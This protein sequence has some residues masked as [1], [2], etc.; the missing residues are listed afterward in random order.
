[1]NKYLCV[2]VCVMCAVSTGWAKKKKAQP[3]VEED[4]AEEVAEEETYE[5]EAPEAP[6]V[7]APAE[8]SSEEVAAE[9][10]STPAPV[11][12]V[13][14]E[15]EEESEEVAEESEEDEEEAE[16]VASKKKK[17]KKKKH[18]EEEEDEDEESEDSDE[19]EVAGA[20]GPVF[21]V[22]GVLGGSYI[23][24]ANMPMGA[25][26]GLAFAYYFTSDIAVRTGLDVAVRTKS[27]KELVVD[28]GPLGFDAFGLWNGMF[29]EVSKN[30]YLVSVKLPVAFRYA[31]NDMFW[32][33]AGVTI[34]GDV[35]YTGKVQNGVYGEYSENLAAMDGGLDAD[36]RADDAF[37]GFGVTLADNFDVGL[38]LGYVE[39]VNIGINMVYWFR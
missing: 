26:V 7:E 21:G 8:E 9:E 32:A 16:E 38:Q 20:S 19:S 10:E 23:S 31:I 30:G 37:V 14:E 28:D 17:S 12:E 13:A 36:F 6:A 29:K 24:S 15:S 5:E 3:V 27:S 35:Y 2:L 34:A 39:C 1:M 25:D 22:H 4:V 18:V 33:E 11:E